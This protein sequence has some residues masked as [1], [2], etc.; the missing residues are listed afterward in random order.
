MRQRKILFLIALGLL[1]FAKGGAAYAVETDTDTVSI[2]VNKRVWQEGKA[3]T[4]GSIE[5]TGE[6]MDFGGQ[7]LADVEFTLYD[8]TAA[9]DRLINEEKNTQ[10]VATK[11]IAENPENYRSM[12]LKAQ[13][14]DSKGQTTFT[15][16]ALKDTN[17]T[18]KTYLLIETTRPDRIKTKAANMVI[19]MPIYR[20][21][22]KGQIDMTQINYEIQI[23]PK[24]VSELPDPVKPDTPTK[25]KRT[26][27]VRLPQT[28]ESKTLLGS[29]G[30]LLVGTAL[31]L[32]RRRNV[33][34]N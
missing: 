22:D 11:I 33:R 10:E 8:V 15:E 14:T 16:L 26:T 1:T 27:K 7:A 30:I 25:P 12:F 28:G 18:H 31:V 20:L 19:A 9:Y 13:K 34:K 21:D 5:N 17:G 32:W 29:L 23:Y 3:P 24:N 4:A 6:V 2:T